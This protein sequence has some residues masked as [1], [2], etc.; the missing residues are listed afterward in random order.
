MNALTQFG[1]GAGL[2]KIDENSDEIASF[3]LGSV[4]EFILLIQR[5]DQVQKAVS[6]PKALQKALHERIGKG[7]TLK[8]E[9]FNKGI[10]SLVQDG[11]IDKALEPM[12]QKILELEEQLFG[13]SI[14][15]KKGAVYLKDAAAV[16]LRYYIVF[17]CLNIE[18]FSKAISLSEEQQMSRDLNDFLFHSYFRPALPPNISKNVHRISDFALESLFKIKKGASLLFHASE[19][20]TVRRGTLVIDV[21]DQFKCEIKEQAPE[22]FIFM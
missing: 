5:S 6:N 13:F 10:H 8:Q 19:E 20:T 1:I 4:H 17:A 2:K 22:E 16:Y 11:G 21:E 15:K 14:L 9:I 7:L 12:S 3:I 18:K